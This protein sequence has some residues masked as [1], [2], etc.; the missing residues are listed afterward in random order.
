MFELRRSTKVQ[1]DNRDASR[2]AI[3]TSSCHDIYLE[4]ANSK[5][6][7]RRLDYECGDLLRIPVSP[8]IGFPAAVKLREGSSK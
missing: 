2:W 1:I 8:Q 7:M 4:S 6:R 5:A 3:T